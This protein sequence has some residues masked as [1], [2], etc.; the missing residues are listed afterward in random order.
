[1][2]VFALSL[3]AACAAAPL[4]QIQQPS[5]TDVELLSSALLSCAV[6]CD[7]LPHAACA[8]APVRQA[9]QAHRPA[10]TITNA[11]LCI[12]ALCWAM[13]GFF[14]QLVEPHLSAQLNSITG[15]P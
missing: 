6:C 7:I 4:S 2:M 5:I 15:S 10:T 12:P 11:K 3:H 8:A 9:Q 14:L 1:M 13:F